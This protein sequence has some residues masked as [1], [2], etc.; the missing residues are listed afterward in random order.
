MYRRYSTN[1]MSNPT[2]TTL[3]PPNPHKA[4]ERPP[5]HRFSKSHTSILPRGVLHQ[6]LPET[7][8]RWREAVEQILGYVFNDPD[9]LEEALEAPGSGVMY[10]GGG[11]GRT[12]RF[13]D[14]EGNRGMAMVGE[15]AME[16]VLMEVCYAKGFGDG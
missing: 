11:A 15:K 10:V 9:L 2:P 1:A 7:A 3:Q 5:S 14:K 13:L 4:P 6:P 8:L 16:L 12:P